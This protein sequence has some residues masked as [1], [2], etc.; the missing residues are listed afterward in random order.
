MGNLLV[1]ADG[2]RALGGVQI[3]AIGPKT[4]EALRSVHLQPDLM[5]SRFQSEDLA[6]ELRQRVQ[7]DQRVLLARADRGRELIRDELAAVCDV[8]QVAVY[9]Q[10]DAVEL[11]AEVLDHLRRGE[12]DYITLTSANI[13]RSLLGRLD[14]TSRARIESGDL[15]LVSISPVTSAEI[16]QLGLPVA[17]EAVEATSEGLVAAMLPAPKRPPP[18]I[19]PKAYS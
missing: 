7:S 19:P 10:V 3:A 5:P 15:R 14:A 13:A 16:R 12:I 18:L 2:L 9:S 11:D 17:A 6:A 1:R 8:E 4:A